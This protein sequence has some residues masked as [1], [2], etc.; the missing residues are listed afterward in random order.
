MKHL[1]LPAFL[2]T[3]LLLPA[4]ASAD[5][6]GLEWRRG[7]GY[8]I[9]YRSPGSNWRRAPGTAIDVAD[10]WVIGTD[11]RSGGYSIYRWDGHRWHR[12][13]GA[14][15]RIGG[16][17]YNPWVVNDRGERF[18][19]TGYGWREEPNFGRRDDRRN[20]RHDNRGRHDN[21]WNRGHNSFGRDDHRG[22]K[23]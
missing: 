7:S 1:L 5:P 15:V 20:D 8:D 6:H 14:G 17:Y 23:R 2:A 16:S 22:G 10:G 3:A 19:W 12:M 9:W 18:T 11:R 21:D 13:P 4:F